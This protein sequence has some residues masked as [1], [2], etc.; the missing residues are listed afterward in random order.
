V[1]L[2]RSIVSNGPGLRED[3]TFFRCR[4]SATYVEKRSRWNPPSYRY[5]PNYIRDLAPAESVAAAAELE[6]FKAL[7]PE[8]QVQVQRAHRDSAE[9]DKAV[10]IEEKR[11]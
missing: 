11:K 2:D 3:L 10:P 7:W 4:D 8:F 9:R 5:A 1:V 6:A